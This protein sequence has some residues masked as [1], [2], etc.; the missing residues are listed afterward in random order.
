[1]TGSAADMAGSNN[2]T[3]K[4]TTDR[5]RVGILG[6]GRMGSSIAHN[7]A[8]AGFRVQAFDPASEPV[9]FPEPNI[10]LKQSEGGAAEGADIILVIVGFDE[11]VKTILFQPGFVARLHAGQVIAVMSTVRPDTMNE[12]R[13]GL[14]DFVRLVDAP[15]CRGQVA[16][17]EG[18]LLALV[19]GDVADVDNVRDVLGAFCTQIERTGALGTG[20]VT[21]MANNV[22]LWAAYFG[23]FESMRLMRAAGVDVDLARNALLSSSANSWAL[24]MW[25]DIRPVWAQDDLEIAQQVAT[26]LDVPAPVLASVYDAFQLWPNPEQ[27]YLAENDARHEG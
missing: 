18:R 3:G 27:T 11:E 7:V 21:K 26:S 4:H 5:K 22:M 15:V 23:V 2:D 6:L 8:R 24:S 17:D 10:E 12:L 19:G 9:L 20:Q 25:P 1:M 13:R 16:A 14:P